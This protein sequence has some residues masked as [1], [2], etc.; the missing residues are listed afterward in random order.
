MAELWL[1]KNWSEEHLQPGPC[2]DGGGGAIGM[3]LVLKRGIAPSLCGWKG[4]RA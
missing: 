3:R 4:D 1:G 2:R